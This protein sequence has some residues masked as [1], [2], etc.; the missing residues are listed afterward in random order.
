[1][2]NSSFKVR[3]FNCEFH[4]SRSGGR[5]WAAFASGSSLTFEQIDPKK[6]GVV[7]AVCRQTDE[8]SSQ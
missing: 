7:V 2:M 5:E 3:E 4:H 1:M 6:Y 8:E